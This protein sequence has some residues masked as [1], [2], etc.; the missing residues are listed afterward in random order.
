M[1]VHWHSCYL[2]DCKTW[3]THTV[4]CNV[5]PKGRTQCVCVERDSTAHRSTQ[6]VHK[7]S[8]VL[9]ELGVCMQ[10]DTGSGA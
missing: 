8:G 1:I 4:C 5:G 2:R 10:N 9:T 3:F 7:A 6:S